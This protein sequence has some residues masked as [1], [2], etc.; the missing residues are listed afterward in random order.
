MSELKRK[1][2]KSDTYVGTLE[3][4]HLE[5]VKVKYGWDGPLV[6][7][8]KALQVVIDKHPEGVVYCKQEYGYSEG[9]T[10]DLRLIIE[11]DETDEEYNKRVEKNKQQRITRAANTKQ[12]AIA[13]EKADRIQY[14]A[15][16]LKFFEE[17]SS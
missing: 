17:D 8:I 10:Y 11:R 12:K 13:Q 6:D 7:V 9:D 5:G 1:V 3:S 4:I 14:E 16:K 15:L 2:I